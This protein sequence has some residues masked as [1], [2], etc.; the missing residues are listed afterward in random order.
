MIADR[1]AME[2]EELSNR[3]TAWLVDDRALGERVTNLRQLPGGFSQMMY[4]FD[5]YTS[6]GVQ[7]LVLRANRPEGQSITA[8]DRFAEWE[9]VESLTAQGE[10]PIPRALFYDGGQALGVPCFIVEHVEGT[11]V[12]RHFAANPTQE[13]GPVADVLVDCLASI[14]AVPLVDL[15]ATLNRPISWEGHIDSLIGRW[16]K[17]ERTGLEPD[18]FVRYLA[19]WLETNKPVAVPMCLVHGEV[20]N[21]NLLIGSDE[22]IT[23]VD[24]EYAHIGDPREDLGWYRTVSA[25]V[26]PD[27]MADNI[28]RV[29]ER[30]R[31]L[32]GLDE[33]AINPT[34]IAYFGLLAGVSVYDTLIEAPATVERSDQAPVLAAY[35]SAVLAGAQLGWLNVIDALDSNAVTTEPALS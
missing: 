10:V 3:L 12:S 33:E 15:P 9:I 20:N 8:T 35:M 25:S 26:P 13:T 34:S 1:G 23:V 28:D 17:L 29:C 2:L 7:S 11:T 31:E 16:R 6:R 24:W 30:Y 19:N 22:S 18:P 5:L 32:T 27:V 21:D 14:H 4:A